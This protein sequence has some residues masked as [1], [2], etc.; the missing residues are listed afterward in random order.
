MPSTSWFGTSISYEFEIVAAQDRQGGVTEATFATWGQL[1]RG[2]KRIL[3]EFKCPAC[4]MQKVGGSG[5]IVKCG[6]L[7]LY[8]Q[9]PVKGWFGGVKYKDKFDKTVW[10]VHDVVLHR[11]AGRHIFNLFAVLDASPGEVRCNARGCS[12]TESG[13]REGTQTLGQFLGQF[14]K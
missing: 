3:A 13:G 10:C 2:V 11:A 6:K 7:H 12:W 14:Q 5:V 8:Q 9:M 4:G 1:K